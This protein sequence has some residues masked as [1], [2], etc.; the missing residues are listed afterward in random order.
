VTTLS[1][2]PCGGMNNAFWL[3]TAD[4]FEIDVTEFRLPNFDHMNLCNWATSVQSHC[5]GLQVRFAGDLSKDFHDFGVLWTAGDLIFEVDGEP[6]GAIRT[7]SGIGSA[8]KLRV[9]TALADWAGAGADDP[10]GHDMVVQSIH[11]RGL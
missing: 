7:P 3:T 5:V 6:V 8:A 4:G 11:V 2:L 10:V 9:A 1:L